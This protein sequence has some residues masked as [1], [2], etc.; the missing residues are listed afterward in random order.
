M[1]EIL[2]D[3]KLVEKILNEILEDTKQE[4]IKWEV[5]NKENQT[6]RLY[7]F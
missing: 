1:N 4:K 3:E 5:K 2:E 6:L 7:D